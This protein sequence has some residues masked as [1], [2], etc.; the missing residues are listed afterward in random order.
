MA[1]KYLN[2]PIYCE[3]QL[4][5]WT[6]ENVTYTVA[7][8]PS[9]TIIYTGSVYITGE[10]QR[11]YLNDI[12]YTIN[13]DY[14]WFRNTPYYSDPINTP[15]V[16]TLI[17]NIAGNEYTVSDI[18][19]ATEVPF[20]PINFITP[21][22]D[23][24]E[25]YPMYTVG[26]GVIPRIPR[27][28]SAI[29]KIFMMTGFMLP[30]DVFA[31]DSINIRLYDDKDNSI[32]SIKS[33]GA[34]FTNSKD[35]VYKY[36][37]TNSDI[38]K[39]GIKMGLG[40]NVDESYSNC[41][42]GIDALNRALTTKTP[43]VRLC[44]IDDNPADYYV[45]WINRLGMWQSQPMNAKWEMKEKVTTDSITTVNNETIPYS[46]NSEFSWTLNT[47]WLT[48]DEHDE[49]ESLLTSK[50]VYLYNTKTYKG[51]YVNITDS[52]WTFKNG[53]NTKKPFNLTVNL[54]KSMNQTITL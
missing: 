32:L 37:L 6:G 51:E 54:T 45:M 53:V 34:E 30:P 20:K 18:V 22:P 48:Y 26:T 11:I 46:K 25:I 14:D 36:L 15:F 40:D 50:Y 49:F 43:I 9:S 33:I 27:R 13:D 8:T 52:N 4:P 5:S 16:S 42:I 47:D 3:F 23:D 1:Y 29:S 21:S 38:S 39:C 17:V 28:F 10:K 7:T 19:H 35:M 24:F 2:E 44:N 41:Y 31:L 12:I